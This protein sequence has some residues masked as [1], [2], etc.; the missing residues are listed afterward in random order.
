M[1]GGYFGAT[2]VPAVSVTVERRLSERR[3]LMFTVAGSIS[4]GKDDG[5]EQD[6]DGVVPIMNEASEEWSG[7][8]LQGSVGYRFVHSEGGPVALF[9]YG[10]AMVGRHASSGS[11]G[12]STETL[13]QATLS[14]GAA[15]GL[16]VDARLSDSV[17]LRLSSHVLQASYQWADWERKS[18]IYGDSSSNVVQHQAGFD[19]SPTVGLRVVF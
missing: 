13:E 10:M 9:T 7:N 2:R 12:G 5:K 15:L 18:L 3:W 11:S 14:V 19:F 8:M 17:S 1:L 16:G 6:L 4:G